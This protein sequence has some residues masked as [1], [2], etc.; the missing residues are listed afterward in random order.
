MWWI[1]PVAK[2]KGMGLQTA[3]FV[4]SQQPETFGPWPVFAGLPTCEDDRH[5]SIDLQARHVL[6]AG[7]VEVPSRFLRTFGQPYM[8]ASRCASSSSVT[9]R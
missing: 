6:A 9:S 8:P 2:Y 1:H 3:A 5:R 4:S 7:P